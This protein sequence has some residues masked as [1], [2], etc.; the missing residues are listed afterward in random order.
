MEKIDFASIEGWAEHEAKLLWSSPATKA[1]IATEVGAVGVFVKGILNGTQD[2]TIDAVK[3]WIVIQAGIVIAFFFQRAIIKIQASLAFLP[4]GI[5]AGAEQDAANAVIAKLPPL[6]GESVRREL[7][8]QQS[9]PS[10]SLTSAA[11]PSASQ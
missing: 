3:G 7:A 8:A 9:T 11:P 10:T 1:I 5:V 6:L 2:L 4:H